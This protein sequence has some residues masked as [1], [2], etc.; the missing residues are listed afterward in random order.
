MRIA[1]DT[2]VLI[3]A[4]D[5]DDLP[6]GQAAR[7]IL[8]AVA[9]RHEPVLPVQVLGEFFRTLRRKA[10][11]EPT[12]AAMAVRR[13][14]RFADLAATDDAVLDDAVGV[15]A[16]RGLDIWDAVILAA[17]RSSGCTV[18]LSED[19]QDGFS[20][21]GVTVANPFLSPGHAILTTIL[22]S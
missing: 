4:E 22:E 9:R 19:F 1:I 5:L 12:A 13:W 7:A 14:R 11:M 3:Y 21:R 15:S 8:A 10:R 16:E 2:N 17:T 18:L 20:W 6:R